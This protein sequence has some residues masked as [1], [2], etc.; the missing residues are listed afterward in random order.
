MTSGRSAKIIQRGYSCTPKLKRNDDTVLPLTSSS[1][2]SPKFDVKNSL[3]S[4][5]HETTSTLSI[6]SVTMA[7]QANG[8]ST[9]LTKLIIYDN[10]EC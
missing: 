2:S 4:G 5:Y 8:T 9:F 7:F 1:S 10:K 3:D 6:T